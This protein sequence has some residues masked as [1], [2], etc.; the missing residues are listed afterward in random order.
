MKT[1]GMTVES[2]LQIPSKQIRMPQVARLPPVFVGG[3]ERKGE[4]RRYLVMRKVNPSPY[5]Q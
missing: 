5:L 1:C 2:S 3:V 4:E